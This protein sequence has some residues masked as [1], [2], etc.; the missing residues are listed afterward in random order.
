MQRNEYVHKRV[1]MYKEI[2]MYIGRVR[3]YNV[4]EAHDKFE[5]NSR[6]NLVRFIFKS[7][8]HGKKVCKFI[9]M[10]LNGLKIILKSDGY[11]QEVLKKIRVEK[12]ER[13]HF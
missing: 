4:R 12:S 3:T 9:E 8:D 1:N 7:I 6:K 2:N 13:K 5:R 11:S 10:F